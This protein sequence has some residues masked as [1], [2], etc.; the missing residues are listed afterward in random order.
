[1]VSFAGRGRQM[2]SV[3]C[4]WRWET[5]C[6]LRG[7][8]GGNLLPTSVSPSCMGGCIGG[9]KTLGFVTNS[10]QMRLFFG[11]RPTL[12]VSGQNNSAP[13]SPHYIRIGT[14]PRKTVSRPMISQGKVRTRKHTQQSLI[15]VHSCP[16]FPS[17]IVLP[18]DDKSR[19][20]TP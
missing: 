17:F 4:L 1:M 5:L 20:R 9:S 10:L 6:P 19:K 13:A 15:L 12:N 8:G 14:T 3:T 11:W 16:N 7:L 2:A 18:S